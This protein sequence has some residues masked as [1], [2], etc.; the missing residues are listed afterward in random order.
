MESKETTPKP[1]AILPASTSGGEA[2]DN[3]VV[4]AADGD[5]ISGALCDKSDWVRKMST[6]GM[7][8]WLFTQSDDPREHL[9]SKMSATGPHRPTLF[10]LSVTKKSGHVRGRAANIELLKKCLKRWEPS[11]EDENE[12]FLPDIQV[13]LNIA[14]LGEDSASQGIAVNMSSLILP[15]EGDAQ[16][17][18]EGYTHAINTAEA[19]F[20]L[21]G[22]KDNGRWVV[23]CE[24][25]NLSWA[26]VPK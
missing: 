17:A 5:I 11:K 1:A 15:G 3:E 24:G 23:K 13:T 18:N 19:D 9:L 4:N 7:T 10:V 25:Q 8:I 14:D 21:R 26:F 16:E 6:E 22:S 2:S 20:E 12:L